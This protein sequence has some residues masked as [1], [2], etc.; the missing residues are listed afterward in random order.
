FVARP[1]GYRAWCSSLIHPHRRR[2]REAVEGTDAADAVPS[3]FG[4]GRLAFAFVAFLKARDEK[5]SGESGEHDAAGLAVVY[6]FVW[7]VEI[8][9]LD[10]SPRFG[11]IVGDLV[12]LLRGGHVG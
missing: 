1:E 7:I 6:D 3:V 2:G 9:D 12:V 11:G 10:H 4:A 5:L 8:D